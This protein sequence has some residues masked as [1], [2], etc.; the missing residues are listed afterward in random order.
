MFVVFDS[1]IWIK[2]LAL[3][4]TLGSAVR[5]LHQRIWRHGGGSRGGTERS[6]KYTS[7]PT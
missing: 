1:N 4:S 7:R 2:E 5:V 3:N 6:S